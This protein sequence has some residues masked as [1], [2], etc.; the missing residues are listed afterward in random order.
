MA[1]N[2]ITLDVSGRKFRTSKS[3]LSV[4]PYFE[5]LLNRWE[6]GAD[7]QADGSYY[8]DADALTF[9]HLLSFMRR[10]SRFPLYWTRKDGF[11]YAL[12]SRVEAEADYFM[13]EGLR[14]WIKQRKYLQAVV[15][16]S[17]TDSAMKDQRLVGDVVIEKYVVR[18]AGHVLCPLAWHHDVR[19]DC[20]R[21]ED[22]RKAMMAN[23]LPMSSAQDELLVAVTEFHF[24]NEILV[25]DSL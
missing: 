1:N 13:L 25:N 18:K 20:W 4:S 9:E 22:C 3:V 24:N 15:T 21:D 5:G 19:N 14:D 2:Q 10:P 8:V 12:Y 16:F 6:E 17:R 7:L 11:D 23:G